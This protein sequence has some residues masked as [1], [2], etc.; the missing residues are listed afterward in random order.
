MK[1]ELTREQYEKLLE[2]VYL[3]NWMINAYRT[4]DYL[5]EY[6]E[7]VSHIFS[8][9][10]EAGLQGKAVKDEMENKYLPSYEFEESLQDFISEYDGFCFWEELLN[11]LAERDALKEFGSMP[12]DKIDLEEFL[13]KKSFYLRRYEQEL[14]E[15]GLQNFQIV[16]G[17]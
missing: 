15:N 4:D 1:L 9:A 16:K 11:R 10:E 12:L 5:E 3:G 2:L 17:S 6:S 14:E 7:L 13:N 8:K